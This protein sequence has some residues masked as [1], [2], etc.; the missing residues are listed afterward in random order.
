MTNCNFLECGCYAITA[1]ATDDSDNVITAVD[2]YWGLSDSAAIDSTLVFDNGDQ[3][4]SPVVVFWPVADEPFDLDQPTPVI[5][6]EQP[7]V[8]P[9]SPH[10]AQ[11]FPNPFNPT[12]TIAFDLPRADHVRLSIFNVLGRQVATLV[13][14]RLGAGSH[15]AVWD[16]A[17]AATGIYFYRLSTGAF[18]TTRK[19]VLVK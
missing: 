12:T 2:N 4:G 1:T 10:L 7:P 9:V 16:A 6:P 14:E 15:E 18:S 13:D 17:D 3:P 11:N 5:E 8:L 19:M